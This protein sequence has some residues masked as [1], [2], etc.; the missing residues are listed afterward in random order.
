MA[1][2]SKRNDAISI[3]CVGLERWM[4]RHVV[5]FGKAAGGVALCDPTSPL[6]HFTETNPCE[7]AFSWSPVVQ[8]NAN[9]IPIGGSSGKLR[10]GRCA[11]D[12]VQ[13]L[14]K[15]SQCL[16]KSSSSTGN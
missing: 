15:R 11:H 6:S 9:R 1:P 7:C 5:E 13:T 16:R 10:S 3:S 4:P 8:G 14:G 12:G 2:E